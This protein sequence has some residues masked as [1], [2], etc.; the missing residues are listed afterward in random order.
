[1]AAEGDKR[2]YYQIIVGPKT[3]WPTGQTP[4]AMFKI[5]D[6]ASN[7]LAI[8]EAKTLVT[9]TQPEDLRFTGN[10]VPALGGIFAGDFHAALA[11]GAVRYFQRSKLPDATIIALITA[12]GGEQVVIPDEKSP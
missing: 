11:D 8:V 1:L 9:W 10:T 2:T 7:T 4:L 3:I 12:T 6:G 5:T